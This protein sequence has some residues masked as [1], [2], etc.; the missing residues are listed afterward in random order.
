MKWDPGSV[1]RFCLLPLWQQKYSDQDKYLGD[2]YSYSSPPQPAILGG[3]FDG[4]QIH[5][6]PEHFAFIFARNLI[7]KSQKQNLPGASPILTNSE[8][9]I[10]Q[11]VLTLRLLSLFH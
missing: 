5:L 2:N 7:S 9:F 8:S 11:N 6:R 4:L 1:S 10:V 3:G